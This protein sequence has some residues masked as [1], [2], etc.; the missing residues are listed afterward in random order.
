MLTLK[1]VAKKGGTLEA[2]LS[3]LKKNKN[4]KICYI[5]LNKSCG[6][7][8]E[9]FD[10]R[11]INPDNIYYIDGISSRISSPKSVKGCKFVKEPYALKDI[12]REIRKA[13]KKG[14]TL[15]VFDSL[16]NLLAYGP[17]VPAGVNLLINFISSFS[18]VLEAK[19]G[20]AIFLEIIL[21]TYY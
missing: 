4:K 18:K 9:T 16:S 20:K 19:K 17:A 12:A 8:R 3:I 5:T 11:K 6:S 2:A 14:H 7:L 15:V 13:I 10:K 1:Y 21:A